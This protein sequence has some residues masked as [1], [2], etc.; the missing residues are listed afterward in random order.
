M[1][2]VD[3]ELYGDFDDILNH[4]HR[5]VMEGSTSAS[6]EEASD[7]ETGDMRCA[8]RAYERYSYFGGN[9]VSLSITLVR[10]GKRVFLSAITTGG[11]QAVFF[12]INTVGEE[13]FLSTIDWV[14]DMY[15]KDKFE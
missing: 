4:L 8:V 3:C 1:A 13:N 10:S 14:I 2:K 9:R 11:S 12:K 5:A 6:F 15:S 7:F